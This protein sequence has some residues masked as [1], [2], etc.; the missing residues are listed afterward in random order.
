MGLLGTVFKIVALVVLAVI[1]L[2]AFLYFTDYG[3]E[4]TITEKGRDAEGDYV[5]L[6]PRLIPYEV[7]Q[8][9]DGQSAQFVCEGYGVTY[10][11]Q[12][13]KYQVRDGEGRVVYDSE[14]G[15]TSAFSPARCALLGA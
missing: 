9:L 6:K 5:V 7:K 11:I 1:G 14:A 13:E 4:A 3:A 2:G 10:H 8:R 12:T 15:L